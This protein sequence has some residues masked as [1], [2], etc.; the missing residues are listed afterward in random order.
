MIILAIHWVSLFV[1]IV[2][3]Y[4][5]SETI[6]SYKKS[7]QLTEVEEPKVKF[8]YIP[9]TNHDCPH[10]NG[11]GLNEKIEPGKSH[12]CTHCSGTGIDLG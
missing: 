6:N 5:I 10:C 2:I 11:S 4:A 12:A 3:G 1:G 8:P 7:N 9:L